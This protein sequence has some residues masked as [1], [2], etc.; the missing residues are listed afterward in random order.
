[1]TKVQAKEEVED[2][3]VEEAAADVA[4]GVVED[5]KTFKKKLIKI[6]K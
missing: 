2:G 4:E 5:L 6:R 1:M 3:V